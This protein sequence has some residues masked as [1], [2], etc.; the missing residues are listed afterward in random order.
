MYTSETEIL[1]RIF[2]LQEKSTLENDGKFDVASDRNLILHEDIE[3]YE[4]LLKDLE[5]LRKGIVSEP[6]K[7][8]NNTTHTAVSTNLLKEDTIP[9]PSIENIPLK[10][11]KT[12]I[13]EPKDTY[14][15]LGYENPTEAMLMESNTKEFLQKI[16]A[17]IPVLRIAGIANPMTDNHHE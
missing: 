5:I 10:E 4:R 9:T 11:E 2:N 1:S 7:E 17:I 6:A 13:M 8:E 14:L 12:P 16:N 3:E 15:I